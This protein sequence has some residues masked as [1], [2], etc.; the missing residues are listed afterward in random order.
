MFVLDVRRRDVKIAES[1]P[2][3]PEAKAEREREKEAR[4]G[5]PFRTDFA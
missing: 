4:V 2:R 1:V 3:R 5:S